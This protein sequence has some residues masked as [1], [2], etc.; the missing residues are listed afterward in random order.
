[1][2]THL[3][4]SPHLD[5]AILSC[6]GTIHGLTSRGER[7]IVVTAMAGEPGEPLPA[8]PVL[9]ALRAS[10]SAAPLRTRRAEDAQAARLLGAQVYHLGLTECAFRTALCGT[11]EWIAL[12]PAD[13]SPFAGV[14]PADEARVSLFATRLPFTDAATIYAPLGV[15]NHVDHLLVRDWALVLTGAAVAPALIFYEEY[16]RA[17]SRTAVARALAY[18]PRALPALTLAPE[19]VPLSSDDL[20]AKLHALACYR[21]H[22]HVLWSD[23]AEMERLAR[24]HMNLIG[25]G[26]PAERYWRAVH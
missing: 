24:A 14:N 15:D 19:V 1:M 3:F 7:V 10:W 21:S 2:G 9:Q 23:A 25:E 20:E 6:G 12:Y 4:L 18:Y 16:P 22:L 26:T 13:D 17:R 8:T 5:D 11:G